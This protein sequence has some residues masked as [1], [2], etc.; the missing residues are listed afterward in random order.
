MV[1]HAIDIE[2]HGPWDVRAEVVL[3]RSWDDAGHLERRVDD[4][5]V[6][7]AEMRGKPVSGNERIFGRVHGWRVPFR[8]E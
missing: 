1:R 6:R 4:A 8:F 3:E 7:I 5:K 2:E